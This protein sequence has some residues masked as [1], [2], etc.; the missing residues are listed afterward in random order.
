MRKITP[1][2]KVFLLFLAIAFFASS[3]AFAKGG[4][5]SSSKNN[6]SHPFKTP[7]GLE[8][9]VDFW[10]KIYSE[11]TTSQA[12]IHDSR[13]LNIIYEV[14]DFSGKKISR[15]GKNRK[16]NKVKAKYRKILRKLAKT[17][18]NTKL[19]VEEKRVRDLVKSGFYKAS[20]DIRMQIG[21][22]NRFRKGLERSGMYAKQ[23]DKIFR[24][25]GLPPELGNLPHV[26]SSFHLGAYSSAGAAGIWQFTRSTGRL[27]M[28]VGYDVDE[29]RDPILSSH[30]AAK[31]LKKNYTTLNYWPLAI[32]AYNHGLHGMKRAQKKHGSDIVRVIKNYRSRTF[33]FASQNFYAE[34]LAALHVS[35]NEAKYF[36]GLVKKKPLPMASVKL[37]YYLDMK[38][39][40]KYFNMSRDEIA[41]ANPALRPP[42][43]NGE[44]RIPKGF[45]FQARMEKNGDLA[46]DYKKIPG[47]LKF[48]RQVRSKW[49]TVRRG[50]TLSQIARRF[51]TRVSTL[52]QLNNIGRRNT[53]YIGRVLRLP[54]A[55]KATNRKF[56]HAKAKSFNYKTLGTLKYKVRRN[57]N[58]TLIAKKYKTTPRELI[59][60][61]K[62]R[63]P[64]SLRLGQIL[65]VPDRV[66]VADAAKKTSKV[67]STPAIRKVAQKVEAKAKKTTLPKQAPVS[68]D[69]SPSRLDDSSDFK[70][71]LASANS[72]GY[73]LNTDRPAFYP[74]SF[75]SKSKKNSK[76]GVIRVD[77]D[78]TLSH[79]AEWAS[80]SVRK[81]LKAN[82][83]KR[84]KFIAY[85]KKIR[86]PLNR[87][88]P[89]KFEE[90]RQEYHKGIQED[91]FN[92]Y[93]V[94]KLVVRNVEKGETLWEICN[95][96]YF[97]PFWL[98]NGY[99]PGKN[100]QAL[101]VGE[102]LIIPIIVP[103]QSKDS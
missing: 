54:G 23:I 39:A 70:V 103:V 97:I 77:F 46:S 17:K 24:A 2:H 63:K 62:L 27:F 9:Q 1:F 10:I 31:L 87:V 83:L 48:A 99:N 16:L 6:I 69:K 79:Y 86:V 75:S 51:R 22:K 21:Q 5:V 88:D 96:Q 78:E 29:R 58:L 80:L 14:V 93:Q 45:T 65:K 98:L 82:K 7:P 33:G 43:L 76:M 61:N 15:R 25:K 47:S 53:I 12:I 56:K 91:F 52:R 36:P 59:R 42:V 34:F 50:D 20:R 49:Y 26:E 68:K 102:P 89:E 19:T 41:K 30:A 90:R 55:G 37:K 101:K 85:N 92:N 94:S 64:N 8:H 67:K 84:G 18:K 74:V 28:K 32:T 60:L 81:I 100:I 44:K 3:S 40:K 57:D 73:T 13:N 4:A 66:L 35:Q 38:T 72:K 71:I 11:Y 95:D